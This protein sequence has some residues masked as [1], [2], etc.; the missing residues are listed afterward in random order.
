M[1]WDARIWIPFSLAQRILRLWRE[2]SPFVPTPAVGVQRACAEGY[3]LWLCYVVG[4][5]LCEEEWL[6]ADLA[7]FDWQ[8]APPEDQARDGARN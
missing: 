3:H 7:W 8:I 4:P 6:N 1:T 2:L 5:F